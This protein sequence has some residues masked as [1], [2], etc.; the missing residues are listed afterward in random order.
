M[1]A[2]VTTLLIVEDAA[3]LAELSDR[4]IRHNCAAGKYPGATKG[5]GGWV[6]PV[7]SLPQA[8]QVRYWEDQR[9]AHASGPLAELP[10]VAIVP[11]PID[12]DAR[13]LAY[14]QA[15]KQSKARADIL[16]AAVTEFEELRAGG[17]T[18][19]NAAAHI[20][21]TY[22][23]SYETL[24]RARRVV[25]GQPHELWAALL[26]PSYKGRTKESELTGEAWDWIKSHYLS[27]S[28]PPARVVIKEARKQAKLSG[29]VLPS[30][31]TILRKIN[32]LP[33]TITI[34]GREGKEAFD[35]TFPAAERDF[36]AYG[37]HD[38]WVS[39]GRR[40]DV[41]C[42]W[43]DGTVSRPFVVAWCDLRTRFVLGARGGVNPS[44]MLTLASLHSALE[45]VKIKPSKALLDNGREYA[46][47]AVT[48]G[49][50]TRYRNKIKEDDPIGALTRMGIVVDWARPYRGQE[51][52]IE[53]FW[54]YIAN[55]VDKLPQFQGAYCGKDTA[56]KPED[57][58]RNK[59]IPIE[60]YAAKL[61][62]I[63]EEFNREHTHRGQG[64][65]GK[66]PAQLYDELIQAEPYKVWAMSTAEDLRLLCLEQKTLTL[67]NKDAS[68][69]FN[70]S[71]YGEK[72]YWSEA[73]ADLPL[74]AR[75]KKYT[76]FYNPEDPDIPVLV[77]DGERMICEARRIGMVGNKEA[78]AQH[79]HNKAAFK[80]PRIA[81]FKE[82]KRAAPVALP[83]PAAPLSIQSV[84]IEKPASQATPAE[85]PKLKELSP[86]VWYDPEQ[87][88]TI[89]KGK[90]AKQSNE[91]DA[92]AIENL[93]RTKE[94]REA[95]RLQKRFGTA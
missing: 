54:K 85:L 74:S 77:Y 39:D 34:Q 57:L 20:K 93:R 60:I 50:K 4:T 10:A 72:R 80:K 5:A 6:I 17:E 92:E 14:R 53:S 44:Q 63:L 21:A 64:M 40:V 45:R 82:V 30:D 81:A 33:A 94:Q 65:G 48:G 61:A 15:P 76:I 27:T 23:I 1:D 22:N 7:A 79:C 38:T 89:G 87:G 9:P 29:W 36:T 46:A 16:C 49:Q 91:A 95:D 8:A 31:K 19:S 41:F 26:L 47:K 37:L 43:P 25:A 90:P 59:A 70:F 83:A 52:P 42:R 62:E 66:A 88:K 68:I 86:G 2:P 35:A 11:A 75:A 73:L 24:W 3:R 84:A 78:A 32:A 51:K 58:D 71:C 56:S 12:A 69:R 28:E 55:H 18:K 13:H 67:N